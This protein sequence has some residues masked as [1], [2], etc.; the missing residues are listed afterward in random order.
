M[1]D[2]DLIM[3][4]TFCNFEVNPTKNK[5]YIMSVMSIRIEDKKR[6][7]LKVIASLEGKTMTEIMGKLIEDYIKDYTRK[8]ENYSE[9][10]EWMKVS[11]P[12]FEEWDNDEDEVYND[13]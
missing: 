8:K 1:P 12:S 11:E 4:S 10:N 6:K 5:Y 2:E 13:L 7:K 9:I 3:K